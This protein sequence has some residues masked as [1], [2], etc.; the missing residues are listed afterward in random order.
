LNHAQRVRSQ[1]AVRCEKLRAPMD[2]LLR[3]AD[4]AIDDATGEAIP[5]WRRIQSAALRL[6]ALAEEVLDPGPSDH[7][8]AAIRLER[9]DLAASGQRLRD[10]CL[11][12]PWQKGVRLEWPPLEAPLWMETNPGKLTA[13]VR[14]L[15]GNACKFTAAGVVR[16][17]VRRDDTWLRVQVADTGLG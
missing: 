6:H 11:D 4:A 8:R 7:E 12:L 15:V 1:H 10:D 3:E 13:I 16:V 5:M 9:V 14:H 2:Q 17:T